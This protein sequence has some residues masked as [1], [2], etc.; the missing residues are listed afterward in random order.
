MPC[1]RGEA[2]PVVHHCDGWIVHVM[3]V[4]ESC[5]P[6]SSLVS[7]RVRGVLAECGRPRL[8]GT[9]SHRSTSLRWGA[10]ADANDPR[11]A[12][13]E[14]ETCETAKEARV[15]HRQLLGEFLNL[16]VRPRRT[17]KL[18]DRRHTSSAANALSELACVVSLLLSSK[19]RRVKDAA[20]S[21]QSVYCDRGSDGDKTYPGRCP[22]QGT[23][24][25]R[26]AAAEALGRPC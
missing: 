5:G 19:R 26:R 15:S 23:P 24:S 22:G 13:G 1:P 7:P 20:R 10:S 21:H 2:Y 6:S 16:Q 9:S 3:R 25:T 11:R 17:R 18:C 4:A 8:Y 12:I 14:S